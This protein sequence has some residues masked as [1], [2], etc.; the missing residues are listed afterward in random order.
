M[1]R[2]ILIVDDEADIRL[3][4]AGILGDEGYQTR[5]AAESDTALELLRQRQPSLIILDIWLQNSTLDGM[6]L[7]NVV[8]AEPLVECSAW[9]ASLSL[10]VAGIAELARLYI[11]G[12]SSELCSM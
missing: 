4:I 1:A 8:K 11:S 12:T 5:E 6:A 2:D 7:L 10:I 3:L 9:S